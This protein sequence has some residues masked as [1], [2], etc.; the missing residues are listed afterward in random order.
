MYNKVAYAKINN[1]DMFVCFCMI[2]QDLS[3]ETVVSANVLVHCLALINIYIYITYFNLLLLY[4]I[5][6]SFLDYV[7]CSCHLYMPC[8]YM[9][10]MWA[11]NILYL[12]LVAD[13]QLCFCIIMQ[14]VGF[15]MQR[16]NYKTRFIHKD[17]MSL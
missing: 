8:L 9:P 4:V 11:E 2:V 5:W 6:N 16:L 17:C 12:D 10:H 15:L 3:W 1:R 7:F 14:I 13:I